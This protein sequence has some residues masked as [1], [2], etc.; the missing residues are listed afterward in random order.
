VA[1]DLDALGDTR[2][3]WNDWLADAGRR[4]RVDIRSLDQQL[5]NWRRLLER[6]AEDHAPVYLRRDAEAAAALRRLQT[7]SVRIGVFT[8]APP[9][10]AR[11]AL[12]HLGAER[13]VEALETGD[14][15]LERL[16]ERLGRDTRIVR[17]RS[18]LLD[19]R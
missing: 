8:A 14:G 9:E 10:L 18:E 13:R 6:F 16:L 2:A 3:L 4:A 5:P 17:T 11:V 15:A 19:L 12:A 1:I 7:R